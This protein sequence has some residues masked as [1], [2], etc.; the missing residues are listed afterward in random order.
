MWARRLQAIA[1]Q[2]LTTPYGGRH[3][4]DLERYAE[5]QHVAAEMTAAYTELEVERLVELFEV[6]QGFATP[7][8]TVRACVFKDDKILLVQEKRDMRWTIPGG[9]ADVNDSPAEAAA[10]EVLE[11]TGYKVEARRVLA[12]YDRMRH[13]H[14][15]M[16]F[17]HLW[18]VCLDCELIDKVQEASPLETVQA[19]FFGLDELPPLWEPPATRELP[20]QH[21]THQKAQIARLFE[22]HYDPSLG[23]DFD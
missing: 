18:A 16:R 14:A 3:P 20:E 2:G 15:P 10:R 11:E 22:L 4:V 9:Y 1:Q 13:P 5:I 7:K 23:A 19:G 17:R 21:R 6:D 8:V 12:V